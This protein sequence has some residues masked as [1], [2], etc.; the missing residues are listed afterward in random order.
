[1]RSIEEL[2]LEA[3]TLG[4]SDIHLICGQKPKMRLQGQI[5]DM[6]DFPLSEEDCLSVAKRL[7]GPEYDSLMARGELD[8]AE[9]ISGSRCRIHLFKSQGVPSLALRILR[10]TIPELG[11][12][13]L[14]PAVPGL[15]ELRKGII[16][17]TGET[18]SG[19]ST[20]LAAMIDAINHKRRAHV[21][22][23]ED[24]VEY[25]YTPDKCIFNQRE[26]GKDTVSFSEGLRASLRE[27]PD[28]ILIGEL[29]DRDTIETAITAAETGHLVFG[30]L[31]TG[32]ASDSV[33]RIV[34][35]FPEG[36]QQQTRLQLSMC[37][38]A[39][40]TQQ[41]IPGLN[42]GRALACEVMVVT[43]AIRNMIRS[44]NTPQMA[45]AIA[46]SAALG[47]QTMDQALIKLVQKRKISR[48]MALS[49]AKD[50]SFVAKNAI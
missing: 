21:V 30:T 40:I 1:M 19:K 16:L 43:D 23:L 18:G 14:P 50:R 17:V 33:D 29:R 37:L 22:T 13:N 49:Y 15:T 8:S 5:T 25:I 11:T 48:D 34:Q 41:L 9:A 35:V 3:K 31:H 12:L 20:T 28:V 7:A 46:T 24:P 4:A 36:T 6:E 32:S 10:D 26:I 47:G 42:S 2:V 27:D 39:V 44:G 38:Q 45:N